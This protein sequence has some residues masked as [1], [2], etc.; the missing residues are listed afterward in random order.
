MDASPLDVTS[1]CYWAHPAR[2]FAH[3]LSHSTVEMIVSHC[4]FIVGAFKGLRGF[5]Y[6]Q[7]VHSVSKQAA[8]TRTARSEHTEHYHILLLIHQCWS[9]SFSNFEKLLFF[10]GIVCFVSGS[11]S[12]RLHF[13]KQAAPSA[14]L[15]ENIYPECIEFAT[16]RK[17]I[18]IQMSE[19]AGEEKFL[20]RKGNICRSPR[21]RG[22]VRGEQLL[23]RMSPLMKWCF[24]I[25]L[26]SER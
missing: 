24:L 7:V 2:V 5:L 14:T 10:E 9:C 25:I 12:P 26:P 23:R 11:S 4:Q 3:T 8:H 1:L 21:R 18:S 17:V 19:A 22:S 20:K 13:V 15:A 6:L 16:T